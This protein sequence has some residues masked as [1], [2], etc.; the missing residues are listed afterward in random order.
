MGRETQQTQQIVTGP[1]TSMIGTVAGV[2]NRASQR[3]AHALAVARSAD[4]AGQLSLVVSLV[5]GVIAVGALLVAF[6]G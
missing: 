3:S 5:S 4:R 1:A 2:A 6:F